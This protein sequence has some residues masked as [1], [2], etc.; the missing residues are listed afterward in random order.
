MKTR[1]AVAFEAKKPLE[2]VEVDQQQA[3]LVAQASVPALSFDDPRV[4]RENLALLRDPASGV[5]IAFVQGG[6]GEADENE[7]LRS[8]GLQV[9]DPGTLPDGTVATTPVVAGRS[10]G[11]GTRRSHS[12]PSGGTR[13]RAENGWPCQGSAVA[14]TPPKLPTPLPWYS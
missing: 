12:A 13:S 8:L 3:D 14:S 5:D 6:A 9:V 11:S 4:A 7:G 2:I 1:A 10:A